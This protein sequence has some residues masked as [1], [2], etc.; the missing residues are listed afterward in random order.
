MEKMSPKKTTTSLSVV[1]QEKVKNRTRFVTF[2]SYVG[3]ATLFV[4]G[5][6]NLS[7][8]QTLTGIVE[9]VAALVLVGNVVVFYRTKKL[10]PA[11]YVMVI[12]VGV[13][14]VLL[15]FL[16]GIQNTGIL[17]YAAYPLIAF[18]LFDKRHGFNFVAILFFATAL[19]VLGQELGYFR[20]AFG[21]TVLFQLLASFFVVSVL[22]YL[23]ASGRETQDRNLEIDIDQLALARKEA[24]RLVQ[25]LKKEQSVI[26]KEKIKDEAILDSM[27]EGVVVADKEG[28]LVYWNHAA[29]DIVGMKFSETLKQDWARQ[30]GVFYPDEVTPMP[31]EEQ[32]L[33]KV[34]SGD[35]IE[36]MEE[37]VKNNA[38][39]Q[40]RHIL[41]TAR[42]LKTTEGKIL[43]GVAVFRDITKEKEVDR[44]KTE[45]VSLASHQLRTPLSAVNWY[46]EMLAAGELGKVTKRQKE[47]IG[48]IGES[49]RRMIE[50]V[51]SFLNVSQIDLGTLGSNPVPVDVALIADSVLSDLSPGIMNKKL[52][53]TK[54]YEKS[55]SYVADPKILAIVLQNIISNA[56]K[57]T[58]VG[59][60]IEV[61]LVL[62]KE[63]LLIKVSDTGYGIPDSAKEKIFTKLFRADNVLD[64]DMNGNGL[65]LYLVKSVVED[66][67]GK[68]WF[69]SKEN[70]GSTFY[71]EL[72]ADGMK[73]MTGS[74]TI[75]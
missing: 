37:F 17:W 13:P 65:G 9:I 27:G 4:F 2:F 51:N 33:A 31:G 66:H 44:A 62:N 53:V 74:K 45:F 5:I 36:P 21:S 57:Y 15:L 42:P 54:S 60:H 72:P 22:T 19:C 47:F 50:I 28:K 6:V 64:K 71:V 59:G 18:Y 11:S 35:S 68:I 58:P 69:D 8:A 41:V 34:L 56:V 38:I 14:L 10:V 29:E 55:V 73:K 67:G 30:Y 7:E 63:N 23:Y 43:G 20:L 16:G 39:P 1:E 75:S 46:T 61:S 3:I 48:R 70:V 40:G 52:L 26:E 49:N 12:M 25:E 24:L 32:A